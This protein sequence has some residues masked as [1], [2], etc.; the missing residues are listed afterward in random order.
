MLHASHAT[1][2]K[3]CHRYRDQHLLPMSRLS[4]PGCSSA[5][6]RSFITLRR[7]C[8]SLPP[9]KAGS[10]YYSLSLIKRVPRFLFDCDTSFVEDRHF[11]QRASP[12]DTHA[13]DAPQ[14][15]TRHARRSLV[16]TAVITPIAPARLRLS[17]P[18]ILMPPSHV[19]RDARLAISFRRRGARAARSRR[20]RL[21]AVAILPADEGSIIR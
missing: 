10:P 8:F 5:F 11:G 4:R 18:R 7:L 2:A 16:T 15:V 19:E 1:V 13:I 17:L 6:E 9:H 3:L 12:S 21:L 14:Y 20:R